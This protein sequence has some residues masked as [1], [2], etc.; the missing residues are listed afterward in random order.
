ML[1]LIAWHHKVISK[2]IYLSGMKYGVKNEVFVKYV[3]EG[4]V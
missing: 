1:I 3:T 2:K 4:Y